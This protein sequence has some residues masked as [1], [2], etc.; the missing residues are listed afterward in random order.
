MRETQL[1]TPINE[2]KG[3]EF[4]T[5]WNN[6]INRPFT[7]QFGADHFSSAFRCSR[8]QHSKGMIIM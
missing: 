7:V 4:V 1:G 2:F 5:V 6:Q 8:M 3:W